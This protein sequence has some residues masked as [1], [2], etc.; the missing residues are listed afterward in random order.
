MIM[1]I[2]ALVLIGLTAGLGYKQG[3]VRAAVSFIGLIVAAFLA[4]PLSPLFAWVFPLVG[5]KNPLAP[6]F[7][8]PII[9]FFLVSFVFK[10]VAAFL[11]RKLEYHFRYRRDDAS[12]AVWEV[13]YKR[14][15]ACVGVLNGVVYFLVF[16][17]LVAVFGYTTL[18]TGGDESDSTVLSF[19]SKSAKDLQD[20][21]MDKVVAGFNPAPEKYFDAADTLG[22]L[23]HNRSLLGRLENY[24]VF[25]AMAEEPVYQTLGADKEL[26]TMIQNKASFSEILNKPSVQEVMTNSDV[27]AR[28]MELDIKDFKHYL[29][30][31]VSP[32]FEKEKLLGRWNYDLL[33][34][35]QLNKALNS[36]VPASSW[37]RMKNEL[38]ERFAGSVL[39][40]FYNEKAKYD[41]APAMEGRATSYIGTP[42][43]RLANGQIVTNYVPRWFNT[44]ATFSAKG[45]WSG[46]APNYLITL[47]NK[48]GTATSEAKL[49][50]G[51][52]SL[53]FEGKALSFRRLQD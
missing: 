33:A 49:Q 53:Q 20:T 30:T 14:V 31:G 23:H 28:V 19:L 44:N 9:A 42:S 13:M 43:A 15:G 12:R 11:H 52:L 6:Q 21:R 48:N 35:L 45:K 40:A 5:F 2:T 24:P 51:Q 8:G 36:Q 1:W 39:T 10:A 32:K 27:V 50:D 37:F 16:S 46:S 41:L 29:E 22:L 3:A 18:Q 47:G 7:G 34:T 26:E 25:A 38:S 17:L 4:I